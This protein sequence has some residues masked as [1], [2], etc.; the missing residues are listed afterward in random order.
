[1]AVFY[2]FM[3]LLLENTKKKKRTSI[4]TNLCNQKLINHFIQLKKEKV[5]EEKNKT[6]LKNK[7]KVFEVRN[8]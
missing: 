3:L 2:G 8:F 5:L 1:M 6:S 7:K 4:L